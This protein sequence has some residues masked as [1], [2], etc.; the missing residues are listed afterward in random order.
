MVWLTLLP[1]AETALSKLVV[2]WKSDVSPDQ[3]RST[4]TGSRSTATASWW[5]HRAGWSCS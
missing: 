4:I 3:Q 5:E 1:S 2:D